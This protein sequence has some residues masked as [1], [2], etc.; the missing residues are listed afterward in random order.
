M[1]SINFWG[2][3]KISNSFDLG[4]DNFRIFYHKKKKSL[5]I[6]TNDS[7]KLDNLINYLKKDEFKDIFYYIIVED[8]NKKREEQAEKIAK[9]IFENKTPLLLEENKNFRY[10]TELYKQSDKTQN[11]QKLRNDIL[12][13]YKKADDM[14]IERLKTKY[15]ENV[16]ILID[17]T[18]CPNIIAEYI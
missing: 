16:K 17:Y 1:D 9:S 12:K 4:Y 8:I 2:D 11:F 18:N 13:V 10:V 7:K 5:K 14:L 3:K 15:G 6:E